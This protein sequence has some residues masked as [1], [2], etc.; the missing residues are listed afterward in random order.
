MVRGDTDEVGVFFLPARLLL[1]K[2]APQKITT[3]F[4]GL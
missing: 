2:G 3:G 1:T 4:A